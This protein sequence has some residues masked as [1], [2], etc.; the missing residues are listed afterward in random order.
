MRRIGGPST[1][2]GIQRGSAGAEGGGLCSWRCIALRVSPVFLGLLSGLDRGG[3]GTAGVVSEVER[4][5]ELQEAR[6]DGSV[7]A[8]VSNA[9]VALH[10]EQFG[11][12]PLRARTAFAGDDTLVCTLEAA[13]L[14][15]E[16]AMVEMGYQHRVQESRLFFQTAT[17]QKFVDAVEVITAREV[18]AFAS[19]TDPDAATVWEVFN[20]A[21]TTVRGT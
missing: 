1:A 2:V 5:D 11:R 21:P 12:G 17:R 10:K 3:D 13:L 15:A 4:I 19:A 16:Q 14:P 20:F 18:V 6:R 7:L 9:L 8:R